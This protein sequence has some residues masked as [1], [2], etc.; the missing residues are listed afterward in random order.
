MDNKQALILAGGAS[1][2]F[3]SDKSAIVYKG[4]LLIEHLIGTLESSG[5]FITILSD[6][7]SHLVELGLPILEDVVP[8]DGPLAVLHGAMT[9]LPGRRFLV[10]ACDMPF[11][12]A[13]VCD[14]LWEK[15]AQTDTVHMQGSPLPGVYSSGL[16]PVIGELLSAHKRSLFELLRSSAQKNRVEISEKELTNIDPQHL[17][18]ININEPADLEKVYLLRRP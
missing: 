8:Y 15:S 6:R 14:M 9:R 11:I 4:R 2:R 3:G 10:V 12:T 17:S 1:K 5:F 18:L 16:C 13:A 7:K